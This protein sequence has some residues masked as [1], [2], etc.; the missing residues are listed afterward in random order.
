MD[1]DNGV[2]LN[3]A[4]RFMMSLTWEVIT[5][6]QQLEQNVVLFIS[7]SVDHAN[8][9][10]SFIFRCELFCFIFIVLHTSIW[11]AQTLWTAAKRP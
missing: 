11:L 9:P 5:F 8:V 4:N 1:V 7:H 3:G 2:C 6:L 10:E